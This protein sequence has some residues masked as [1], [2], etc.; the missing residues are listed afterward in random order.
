MVVQFNP[1]HD[2]TA[3]LQ[4]EEGKSKAKDN[5]EADSGKGEV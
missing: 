3:G 1:R 4:K 2:D 5:M